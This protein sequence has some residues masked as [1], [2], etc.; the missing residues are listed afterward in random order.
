MYSAEEMALI[1][2]DETLKE[3][4]KQFLAKDMALRSLD[5]QTKYN[6]LATGEEKKEARKVLR[7]EV[8]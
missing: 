7:P 1:L 6:A 8:F 2:G 4:Y 5:L 3:A